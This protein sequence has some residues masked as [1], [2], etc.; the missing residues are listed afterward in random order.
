MNSFAVRIP[1]V[2]TIILNWNG[3]EDTLECIDSLCKTDYPNNDIFVVVNG[4][5]DGC[6]Q[7]I[8]K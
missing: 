8:K 2:V 3:L 6:V 1:K 4:S 7:I 5:S